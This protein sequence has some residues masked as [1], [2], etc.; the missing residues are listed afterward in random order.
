LN[1]NITPSAVFPGDRDFKIVVVPAASKIDDVNL[2]NFEV[3][4]AVYGFE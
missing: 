3:V 4:K 2:N 1:A